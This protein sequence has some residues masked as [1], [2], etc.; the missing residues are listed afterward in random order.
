MAL[1]FGWRYREGEGHW[2]GNRGGSKVV[3]K[4]KYATLRNR[5]FPC[6]P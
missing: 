5:R 1:S 6:Q 4:Y 3:D 2:D